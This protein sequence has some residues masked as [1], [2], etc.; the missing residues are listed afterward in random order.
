MSLFTELAKFF[1]QTQNIGILFHVVCL[2]GF[3]FNF[4]LR[5]FCV[6]V[7]ISRELRLMFR[8][9]L[10]CRMQRFRKMSSLVNHVTLNVINK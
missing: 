10:G 5:Y 7:S 3:I 9:K 1:A 8:N 4:F 6:F 2:V